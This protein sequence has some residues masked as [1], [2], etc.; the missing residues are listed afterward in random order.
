MRRAGVG[1]AARGVCARARVWVVR[2]RA[3]RGCARL[4]DH[5]AQL[6]VLVV[7]PL[8]ADRRAGARVGLGVDG[9]EHGECVLLALELLG[10]QAAARRW[11][12]PTRCN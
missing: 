8:Q 12:G 7:A 6:A 2:G 3:W 1:G 5:P 11:A 10:R 4:R 9:R